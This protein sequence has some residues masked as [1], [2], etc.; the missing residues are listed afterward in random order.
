MNSKTYN[1]A[2]IGNIEVCKH[3]NSK[4]LAIKLK[5]GSIP[6]VVIPKLMTYEMGFRFAVEKRLW[7]IEHTEKIKRTVSTTVYDISSKLKTQCHTIII[8]YGDT[9]ALKAV[10][11]NSDIIILIPKDED[12]RLKNIQD[13]IK[14]IIIEVFRFEA[15]QILIPRVKTLAEKYGFNYKNIFIKNLKSRWGSCSAQNNINLNL[16]LVRLPEYLSDFIIL[17]ELCHTIHKNHGA[18]F[19][20]LLNTIVGNEKLLNKELK[21]Y[22]TQ[23]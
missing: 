3:H 5:P 1:I 18:Q 14:L 16:H 23:L 21:N 10:K 19:H 4:R 9:T 12:I 15:K 13:S 20:T 11:T 6:K 7:I 2:G 22:T 8:E 17:H